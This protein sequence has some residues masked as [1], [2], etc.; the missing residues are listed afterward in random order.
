MVS[1]MHSCRQVVYDPDRA[2]DRRCMHGRRLAYRPRDLRIT[3]RYGFIG[4]G[5]LDDTGLPQ[6][7][8][9]LC[10]AGGIVAEGHAWLDLLVTFDQLLIERV[11]EGCA[12]TAKRH[13]GREM[14]RRERLIASRRGEDTLAADL[15]GCQ[16]RNH[17]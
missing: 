2:D 14:P 11:G 3:I 6:I 9:P 7:G 1:T 4:V 5:E 12:G 16:L 15:N 13:R 17:F 10:R 8:S